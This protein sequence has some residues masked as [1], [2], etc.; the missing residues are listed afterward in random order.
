MNQFLSIVN[1]F[2]LVIYTDEESR[3]YI[4]TGGNPR[5]LVVVK[6]LESFAMYKYKDQWIENHKRNTL[7]QH[8]VDWKVNMLWSEKIWFVKETMEKRYFAPEIGKKKNAER[9]GW[10]DIGYFRNRPMDLHTKDLQSWGNA[11]KVGQLDKT[12]IAYACINNFEPFMKQLIQCI[13]TKNNMGLPLIP[14][15]PQQNSIAGGFF[16]LHRD[17]IKGWAKTYED[18]LALYFNNGYLVKD[19]QIILAD[20]IF[21]EPGRFL[22]FHEGNPKFDN[23]FMFQRILL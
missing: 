10:C 5:I 15:P 20:C 7:L 22:L 14:I 16:V 19:D 3:S 9:F 23:W 21:S 17:L 6:P 2:Y 18:K 13:R 12:K 8:Q 11:A 1:E 4:D